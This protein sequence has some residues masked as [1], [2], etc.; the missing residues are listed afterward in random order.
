[1]RFRRPI[2]DDDDDHCRRR[3]LNHQTQAQIERTTETESLMTMTRADVGHGRRQEGG[4]PIGECVIWS[5]S[6]G[7]PGELE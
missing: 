3:R 7:E 1:L 4:Y 5:V 2:G 6:C